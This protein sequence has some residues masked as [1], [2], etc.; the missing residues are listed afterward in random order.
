MFG[1]IRAHACLFMEKCRPTYVIYFGKVLDSLNSLNITLAFYD[2]LVWIS[3]FFFVCLFL[4]VHYVFWLLF[5]FNKL[6]ILKILECAY[7]PLLNVKT[8][9]KHDSYTLY[10]QYWLCF[11]L[12]AWLIKSFGLSMSPTLSYN[13]DKPNVWL[14]KAIN[15]TKCMFSEISFLS[16]SIHGSFREKLY[17]KFCLHSY[18]PPQ[19][20]AKVGRSQNK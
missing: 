1:K 14:I 9:Y 18:I 19:A 13:L 2:S 7:R 5:F 20:G 17:A 3:R 4:N 10:L 8:L 6:W 12:L 11:D 15:S 16:D